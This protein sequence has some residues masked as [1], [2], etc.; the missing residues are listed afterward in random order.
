MREM[1]KDYFLEANAILFLVDSADTSRLE[2]AKE[3]LWGILESADL[4]DIPILI[5]ANKIDMPVR[6]T[7]LRYFFFLS[8]VPRLPPP[9]TAAFTSL[10]PLVCFSRA[11]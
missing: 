2:E 9:A 6:K 7:S 8:Q 4:K 10:S 5:L 3:E 11:Q 1:W